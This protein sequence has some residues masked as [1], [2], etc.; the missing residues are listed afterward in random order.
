MAKVLLAFALLSFF[1][2]TAKANF[3]GSWNGTATAYD[4]QGRAT[5]CPSA[6]FHFTHTANNFSL[7]YGSVDCGQFKETWRAV[8]LM[9]QGTDLF[10]NGQ[11]IGNITDTKFYTEHASNTQ[12]KE[13]YSMELKADGIKF[14]QQFIDANG[15][16]VFNL[17]GNL[18]K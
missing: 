9:I 2:A 11:K 5:F 10:W 16:V 6:G 4:D 13:I 14:E 17:R 7:N 8:T 3:T 1:S 15:K 12:L 18:K